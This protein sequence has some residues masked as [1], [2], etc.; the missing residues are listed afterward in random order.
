MLTR[1]ADEPGPVG[2]VRWRRPGIIFILGACAAFLV[3]SSLAYN[4]TRRGAGPHMPLSQVVGPAHI[5][6]LRY[7]RLA[8]P[9]SVSPQLAAR[10]RASALRAPLAEEPFLYVA[11]QHL[12]DIRTT[13]TPR[14]KALLEEVLRRN[15]R[16][17]EAR[18]RLIQIAANQGDLSGAVAQ[19]AVLYRLEGPAIL[20]V[21]TD[22]GQRLLTIEEWKELGPALRKY[23]ELAEPLVM[24]IVKVERP[25]AFV[26]SI[27]A[28]VPKD[29]A[30]REALIAL[31]AQ[32]LIASKQFQAARDVM[33]AGA[34]GANAPGLV[35]DPSFRQPGQAGPFGWE[36]TQSDVGVAEVQQ[37]GGVLVDFYGRTPGPL[38]QQL[39][40]L[41]PGRYTAALVYTSTSPQSGSLDMRVVCEGGAV[42]AAQS[43]EGSRVGEV[44]NQLGFQVPAQGCPAQR[45]QITGL[46]KQGRTEQIIVVK[47]FDIAG[48]AP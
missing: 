11:S 28:S 35:A 24:G 12:G 7:E 20:Q 25:P 37:G 33:Q 26:Q 23:P 45:L 29:V 8:S 15:P 46:S 17:R 47:Q 19:I 18:A 42:L 10:A 16:S 3:A 2:I 13:G 14:D 34:A 22:L 39:V 40:T 21:L 27:A 1:S 44:R 6:E 43:L 5:F 30:N 9:K 32:R 48:V 36:L 38:L 41:K 4:L 31:L